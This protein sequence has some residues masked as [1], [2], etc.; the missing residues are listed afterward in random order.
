[1]PLLGSNAGQTGAP[2]RQFR[3]V[4][5]LLA[6]A[7]VGVLGRGLLPALLSGV[8]RG[9]AT[10]AFTLVVLAGVFAAAWIMG[11][12]GASM[13]LGAFLMGV[14]LSTSSFAAQIKAAVMPAR[15]LLLGTFFVAVGMGIDLKEAAAFRSELL[16]YL[17]AV[18]L[19]KLGAI[20]ASARIFRVESGT[21][22][23]AGLLLMPLDEV[24]YV[25]FAEAAASGLLSARAH[26]LALLSISFSFVVSPLIID[27][28]LR[29]A[30]RERARR[31]REAARESDL[32][33]PRDGVIVIGYSEL[34]RALCA[35]LEQA[36]VGYA[37]FDTDPDR[38]Q[39]ARRLRHR[40]QYGELADVELIEA[41][42][43]A[44]AR[45]VVVSLDE[46]AQTRAVLA[47]LK[48]RAP[49]VPIL[50]AVQYLD[51][52]DALRTFGAS[53]VLA[54]APEGAVVFARAVL[55]FLLVERERIHAILGTVCANDYAALRGTQLVGAP[56][57]AVIAP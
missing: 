24:G 1:V 13:A 25:I 39:A 55:E 3:L 45:L 11:R 47:A 37:C 54:L 29:R 35:V 7:A 22:L 30:A 14:L 28:A 16:F 32:P 49:K 43:I 40:V 56:G 17:P 8:A 53:R 46:F 57:A 4:E 18:L 41:A 42:G 19:L 2:A 52:R 44:T 50:T 6:L 21:A 9:A 10:R 26:T 5:A 34:G 12:A 48:A 33:L 15:H 36:G 38:V 31:G 23:L 51:E 20:Y 27:L